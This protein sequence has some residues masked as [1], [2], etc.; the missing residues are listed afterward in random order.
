[1]F[2]SVGDGPLIF[3]LFGIQISKDSRILLMYKSTYVLFR[4]VFEWLKSTFN[5]QK[6]RLKKIIYTHLVKKIKNAFKDL[7]SL[8]LTK[9]HF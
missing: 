7:K 1:M 4:I 9:K 3:V 8:K 2:F 5:T 6:I